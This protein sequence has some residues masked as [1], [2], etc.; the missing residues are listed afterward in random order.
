MIS[1]ALVRV[2]GTESGRRCAW[3]GT[4]FDQDR[5][6]I[7][8]RDVC[9]YRP[10]PGEYSSYRLYF[11]DRR[12]AVASLGTQLTIPPRVRCPRLYRWLH[13]G[14]RPTNPPETVTLSDI[15]IELI[16]DESPTRTTEWTIEGT[17]A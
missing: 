2:D 4:Y 13:R 17:N 15:K 8:G 11:G 16:P 10:D 12:I 1:I 3:D 6:L 9:F 7:R 14:R 5:M